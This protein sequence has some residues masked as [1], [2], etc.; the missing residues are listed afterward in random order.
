[1]RP[2]P[3]SHPITTSLTSTLRDMLVNSF[4]ASASAFA[5]PSRRT[6]R[7][8]HASAGLDKE[9]L[10]VLGSGWA[11]YNVARQVGI[12]RAGGC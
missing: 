12:R 7:Q 1:M 6:F 10:V 5:G 11:G 4:R 8:F 9:R 3:Y 2:S